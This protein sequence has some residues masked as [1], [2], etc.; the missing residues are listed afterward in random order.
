MK[1]KLLSFAFFYFSESGLFN[2]LRTIQIKKSLPVSHCVQNA[3]IAFL[4]CLPAAGKSAGSIRRLGK[5]ITLTSW[6]GRKCICLRFQRTLGC[7]RRRRR[8]ADFGKATA[9]SPA[10]SCSSRHWKS[11]SMS[12]NIEVALLPWLECLRAVRPRRPTVCTRRSAEK[13]S[14]SQCNPNCGISNLVSL[15]FP[16]FIIGKRRSGFVTLK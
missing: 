5:R 14:R 6:F 12:N 3:T 16:I 7:D 13:P 2:G 4:S 11:C 9:S 15:R 1:A 8:E 10:R